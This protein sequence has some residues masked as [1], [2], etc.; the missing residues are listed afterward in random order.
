MTVRPAATDVY[1]RQAAGRQHDLALAHAHLGRIDD[2]V[3][4]A[5]LQ[6]AVLVDA[7]S[8]IHI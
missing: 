3:G 5:L 8:L 2:L 1:K 4:V 6:H 7:L